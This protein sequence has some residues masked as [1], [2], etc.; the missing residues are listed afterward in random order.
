MQTPAPPILQSQ[1]T[2]A[3]SNILAFAIMIAAN[4]LSVVLPL[5]G[6]SQLQLSA[7]YDNLFTPAG[8]T[9]S[10]WGII[11]F[12]LAGFVVYAANAL[13]RQQ[14]PAKD[15]VAAISPLF[16]GACL[17]NAAWIFA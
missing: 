2:L 1:R 7:Q 16:I 10:V 13:L 8:F 5:N 14:H 9:F 15:T 6:K 12:F 4:T 17:C 3:V 11:Y